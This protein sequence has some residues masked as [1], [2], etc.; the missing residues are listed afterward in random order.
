MVAAPP[1][2]VVSAAAVEEE[3]SNRFA[4]RA[5]SLCKRL[6]LGLSSRQVRYQALRTRSSHKCGNNHRAIAISTTRSLSSAV[7]ANRH[8]DERLQGLAGRLSFA[9][10]HVR[11]ACAESLGCTTDSFATE[12]AHAPCHRAISW[13]GY[14][15]NWDAQRRWDGL[16]C[17]SRTQG[18]RHRIF[19]TLLHLAGKPIRGSCQGQPW[20]LWQ[21]SRLRSRM[22]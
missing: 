21:R 7:A 14:C 19:Q 18:N 20:P 11:G 16:L 2:A 15:G 17:P 12:G 10:T 6:A 5:R 1:A 9:G 4:P 22:L 13:Q 8:A 3:A